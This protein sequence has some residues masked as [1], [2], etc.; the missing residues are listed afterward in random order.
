MFGGEAMS[1]GWVTE[2]SG[3]EAFGPF[4][5]KL[6]ADLEIQKLWAKTLA[7]ATLAVA[8]SPACDRLLE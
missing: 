5:A 7:T 3:W 2:H 1:V 4:G 8:R 6:E